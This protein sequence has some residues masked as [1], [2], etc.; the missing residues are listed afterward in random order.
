MGGAVAVVLCLWV[1]LASAQVSD[2]SA[3]QL[4]A[5]ADL[6]TDLEGRLENGAVLDEDIEAERVALEEARQALS[7]IASAAEDAK[8]PLLAELEALGS[9]PEN[10]GAEPPQIAEQRARLTAEITEIE[11]EAKRAQ[12]E[13]TRART[14]LDR[15]NTLR[16]E[17]FTQRLLER[18]ESPLGAGKL[19]SAWESITR[20][21]SA[22]ASGIRASFV[23]GADRGFADRFALPIILSMVALF[24]AL[25]LRRWVVDWLSGRVLPDSSRP[26]RIGLGILIALARML[27]PLAAVVILVIATS[28]TWFDAGS[29]QRLI[30]G[31][32]SAAIIV[33]AANALG[34]AFYA[35]K[36][37]DLRMSN[38]AEPEASRAHYG[39]M[40]L[41]IVVSLHRLVVVTGEQI[42]LSIDGLMVLN[43]GLLV[44]GGLAL[45]NFIHRGQVGRVF[46]VADEDD[47]DDETASR[48]SRT[49][50][51]DHLG[52][53]IR[54]LGLAAAVLAPVLAIIGYYKASQFV[55]VPLVKSGALIGI[56]L[57]IYE[58]AKGLAAGQAAAE[59]TD[60]DAEPRRGA[61]PVLIGFLL[62]IAATPL[63][64]LVWGADQSD[65]LEIWGRIVD[66]F[67][68]GDIVI[69]PVDFL[70]FAIVFAIG[71]IATRMV[72]G[73]LRRS[74]LPL[75]RLDQG[76]KSA[77][78]AGVGYVGVVIAALVAISTTG[79]D[80]SNLA[81]V[82]GALSVG[83]GFGLQNVV[84]NFVSGIILLI[85][86]PIKAGD[87]VEISGKHGTVR[88]V[89]VRSTEIQTFDRSTMFVPNADLISGTVTNWT[90]SNSLG[91]LIVKVGVAYGSDARQVEKVL[92][93]IAQAHPMLMRR[94]APYV[95]MMDFGAD[96]LDFEIRGVLRDVNWILNVGSDIRFSIYERFNEEGI[97]IPFAQRDVYIKNLGE[98]NGD[99]AKPIAPPTKN[100][101]PPV[102]P[103]EG[104]DAPDG[105]EAR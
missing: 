44:L 68:V 89:N 104:D 23:I 25:L 80:L 31:L 58:V 39:L 103:G 37:P 96:S 35:P 91:R 60:E 12:Q 55:F 87:W 5:F 38:L 48:H 100:T 84:N 27:L 53:A 50:P 79:L 95:V 70:L 46:D 51:L 7:D 29:G 82:A 92:L 20:A 81:I 28:G 3:G 13:A 40:Y 101:A 8:A 21:G 93:E 15:L 34:R 26:K 24:I 77:S 9:A 2:D 11:T 30:E 52:S 57:L 86:R 67:E 45:W 73:V 16:R 18:E 1:S 90:H 72:Q 41:A 56:C 61:I 88:K 49:Q 10:G 19:S 32:V 47:E 62:T 17:R 6:A 94:P 78:L 4:A 42:G 59:Q 85:E 14:L 65:L 75:T 83:I 71:Y 76:A 64:A 97:E 43:A 54:M 66:G 69:S 105:G 102:P 33:I 99:K 63:L 98:L 74:V 36:A 22:I